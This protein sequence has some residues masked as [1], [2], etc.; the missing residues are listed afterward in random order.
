MAMADEFK[1]LQKPRSGKNAEGM[2]LN[3]L[4]TA[5]ASQLLSSIARRGA[6]GMP[7]VFRRAG[8]PVRKTLD[9]SE[10]RRIKRYVGVLSFGYFSL[11]KQRKVPRLSVREPTSKQLCL[12]LPMKTIET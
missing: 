11:D 8:K 9:K 7:R 10:K 12:A 3:P 2:V 6:A 4:H 1:P 5:R